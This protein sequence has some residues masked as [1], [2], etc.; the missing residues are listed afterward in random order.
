M[1]E[2]QQALVKRV[3]EFLDELMHGGKVKIN[4]NYINFD[5]Y[6]TI[7]EGNTIRKYIYIESEQGL[8]QEAQ[9]T[10]ENGDV[11]AIKP[12]NIQKDEDGLMLAFEFVLNVQEV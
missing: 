1:N 10:A 12:V 4:G 5:A 11:L 9:L 2:V 7:I 3:L 8:V 6:K